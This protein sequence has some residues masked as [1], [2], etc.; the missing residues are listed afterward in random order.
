[1]EALAEP[2]W[3]WDRLEEEGGDSG[4]FR[5]LGWYWEVVGG[6]GRYLEL[7]EVDLVFFGL[8]VK[9]LPSV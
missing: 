3:C 7:A 8:V 2:E 4:V 9:P 6:E 5:K 1:M